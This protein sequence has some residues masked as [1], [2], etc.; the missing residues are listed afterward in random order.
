MDIGLACG[1]RD[2]HGWNG[3]VFAMK[4]QALR[5]R[6]GESHDGYPISATPLTLSAAA[7]ALQSTVPGIF[8]Q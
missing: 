7:L 1:V 5:K 2:V 8:T 4:D 6:Q 3:S